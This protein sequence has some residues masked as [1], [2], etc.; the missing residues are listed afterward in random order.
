MRLVFSKSIKFCEQALTVV[1]RILVAMARL[2]R[3][4]SGAFPHLRLTL[5]R[6]APTVLARII[7]TAILTLRSSKVRPITLDG[8]I[9]KWLARLFF[10]P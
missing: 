1:H 8:V 3:Q 6:I 4:A 2:R 5:I 9:L 10:K 7:H